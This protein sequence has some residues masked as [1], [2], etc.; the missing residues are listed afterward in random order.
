M[1][2]LYFQIDYL[3]IE[4]NCFGKMRTDTLEEAIEDIK[5][6][7]KFPSV[8]HIELKEVKEIDITEI[9]M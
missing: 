9:E 4:R 6:L 1:V 3:C 7:K 2:K 5:N 8:K